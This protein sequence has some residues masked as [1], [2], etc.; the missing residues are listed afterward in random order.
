MPA[1]VIRNIKPDQTWLIQCFIFTCTGFTSCVRALLRTL[2][3]N[4]VSRQF[5]LQY[6]VFTTKSIIIRYVLVI[7]VCLQKSN[8]PLMRRVYTE[9]MEP[10]VRS[11]ASP[12]T[13]LEGLQRLC[14]EKKYSFLTLDTS[15]KGLETQ[16]PCRVVDITYAQ[17]ATTLSMIIS[18]SSEYKALFKY[19]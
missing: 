10:E 1:L 12:A 13:D 5:K 4:R 18:K 8:D 17:H 19:Q 6:T 14:V 2:T 7:F 16:I 15:M 11:N 9:L 3:L